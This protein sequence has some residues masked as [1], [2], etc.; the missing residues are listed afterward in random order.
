MQQNIVI[1]GPI[2][3]DKL[4]FVA[5]YR[6]QA[7]FARS[8]SAQTTADPAYGGGVPYQTTQTD[9]RKD[10]KLDWQITPTQRL[11]WQYNK[12]QIDVAGIDYAAAFLGGSTSLA[13]L[14]NQPNSYS[15]YTLGYQNQLGSDMVLDLHYGH[16]RETL[17]GPGGGGQGPKNAP[18]MI[19]LNTFYAFDNGFFGSDG[20]SRP[21]ENASVSLLAFLKGAGEHELKAGLDWYQ[22]SH[23]A[24]NSQTPSNMLVYFAGFAVDPAAGGSTDL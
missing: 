23:S 15:Y 14:S 6:A 9:E 13:T 17:G 8:T 12:T 2:I 4:F 24:A 18:L 11:F 20:D 10:L 22:S 5:G 21:I 19:D 3:K 16:K 7:P 1:S